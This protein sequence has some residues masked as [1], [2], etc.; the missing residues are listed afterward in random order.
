MTG[1]A[2]KRF[3]KDATVAQAP[4][5]WTVH[6]DARPLKTPAKAPLVVPTPALAEM[7]AEEWAAQGEQIR[8]ET[9]PATRAANTAIDRVRLHHA[10]VVAEIAAYGE[11]DLLC[12][13]A[14]GPAEL[15]ARQAAVW[16]PLLHWAE[17]R[18]DLRFH[19]VAGVMPSPQPP[20]TLARLKQIVA[21]QDAFALTALHDLVTLP[22]SLVIGLAAA[23]GAFDPAGLWQAAR[24]DEDW[25][26]ELWGRDD[27]AEATAALRQAAFFAAFRILHACTP[28]NGAQD[29]GLTG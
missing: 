13:R 4:G 2:R 21:A 11:T 22:G 28:G 12:Y 24:L 27:E 10:A 5:G 18:F 16:D 7:I 19:R 23:D 1:W 20:E 17:T 26:A 6:L 9:M 25:Q 15:A 3:W 29:S 14:E 8:P